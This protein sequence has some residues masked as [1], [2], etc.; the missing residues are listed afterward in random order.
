MPALAVFVSVCVSLFFT[1]D[2]YKAT[3]SDKIK[4][5]KTD[6]PF[7]LLLTPKMAAAYLISLPLLSS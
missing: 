6:I 2:H 1:C 4:G 7:Y 5:L 3:I